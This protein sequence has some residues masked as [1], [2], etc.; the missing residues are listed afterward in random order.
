MGILAKIEKA[1]SGK[2]TYLIVVIVAIGAGLKMLGIEIPEF[3]YP[4][5]GALGLGAIRSAVSKIEKP[6][7]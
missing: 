3:V 6:T 1:L 5:L 7:A 4:I 2:K